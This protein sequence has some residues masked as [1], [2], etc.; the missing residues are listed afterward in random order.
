MIYEAAPEPRFE[1]HDEENS[2]GS[3]G[4]SRPRRSRCCPCNNNCQRDLPDTRTRPDLDD[5][6]RL[7][8]LSWTTGNPSRSNEPWRSRRPTTV[9]KQPS[10]NPHL[11]SRILG[12]T[13]GNPFISIQ[14]VDNHNNPLS[15]EIFLGRC[16]QGLFNTSVDLSI[17][18]TATAQ[19]SGGSCDNHGP[20]ISLSGQMSLTGINANL[21]FSNNDNP[22]G[23]PHQNT[24]PTVVS[25]VLIPAGQTV[26]FAK[27]PPLGGAGGNPWIFLTFLDGRGQ[28]VSDQILLGRCVQL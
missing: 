12:G 11:H 28:P 5:H 23:G 26:Q 24:Q 10:R 16:V 17:P 2:N 1:K 15:N 19:V 20:T 8:Q 6:L 27:Q 7:R 9:R 22:V 21:I 14:F 3:T 4:A 25:V 13:G 18:A